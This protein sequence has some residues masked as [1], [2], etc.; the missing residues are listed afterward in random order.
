MAAR[1]RQQDAREGP[2]WPFEVTE[3]PV[4]AWKP[5]NVGGAKGPQFKD[6]AESDKGPWRLTMSLPTLDSVQKLR[7]ALHAKAKGEPKYRFY[8]L[9]DKVFRNDVLW[10]AWRRCLANQGVPGADGKTFADIEKYGVTKWLEELAEDLKQK[11]YQPQPVRR[12]YIPKA[13]GKQR[14]LGI[15]T[16]RDRVV[17]TAVL[18]VL[19]PIFE[20]DLCL[21]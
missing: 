4:V 17:Q 8:A 10:T 6:N 19:E 1:D 13:D 14:P 20:A 5:S 21:P 7:T 16:I 2:A 12:V 3:R 18:V 9:Y 15:P 11:T